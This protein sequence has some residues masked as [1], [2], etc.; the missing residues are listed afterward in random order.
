[1]LRFVCRER[2]PS[3]AEQNYVQ[4]ESASMAQ[5]ACD[6]E[7]W[8]CCSIGHRGADNYAVAG[9]PFANCSCITVSLRGYVECVVRW[10]RTRIA[11]GR[12][13]HSC[14]LVLLPGPGRFA[15]C[16]A[17]GDSAPCRFYGVSAVCGFAERRATERHG[18]A[19]ARAR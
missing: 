19:Q 9:A 13:L 17:R 5:A 8:N 11:R 2:R 6:L 18:I 10:T 1:M 16:Q 3:F 12:P 15:G 14:F 4:I 7:L